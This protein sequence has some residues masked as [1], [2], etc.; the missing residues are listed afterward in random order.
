MT[1]AHHGYPDAL[2]DVVGALLR[3]DRQ[4]ADESMAT[5]AYQPPAVIARRTPPVRALA[6][7]YD[8]DRYQ[9]RY[10]GAKT[11]LI[12]VMRLIATAYPQEFPYHRHGKAGETY[13]AFDMISASVDHVIPVARGG[14]ALDDNIV[15]ACWACNRVKGNLPLD[16]LGWTLRDPADDAWRGLAD[17]YPVLWEALGGP[18]LGPNERAWLAAARELYRADR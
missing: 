8:R 15:T 16:V 12:P 1:D 14:D 17:V 3:R 2:R 7:I 10:C 4:A 11:V 5:I 13:P 18:Q 9:C 6:R